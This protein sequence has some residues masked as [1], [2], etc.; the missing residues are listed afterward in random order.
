MN[1][2]VV[3]VTG[4][5]GGVGR[6]AAREFAR[7]GDSVALLARGEAGLDGARLDVEAMGVRALPVSVDVADADAVEAAADRVEK[8]LGPVDVWVNNAMTTVFSPVSDIEPE[9]Y[10]RATEVTYLGGVWGTMAALRRMRPRGRGKIVNVGSALAYRSIPLQ[11]AY[12]GAKFALRGFTDSVRCEL[13]HE[14]SGVGITMVHL[15]GLD[16]PQFSWCRAKL[17]KTPQPVPP[18]YEPEVA[19]RAIEWASRNDRREV[20]VGLPVYKTI[21]GNKVAPGFLDRYLADHAW[22][23]QFTDEPLG[24]ER[25]GNL[26]EPVDDERDHGAHGSFAD[27]SRTWSPVL[28]GSLHPGWLAFGAV[29]LGI[30]TAWLLGRRD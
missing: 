2:R 24:G 6:A 8:E 1:G 10:R 17:P 15:P 13:I 26:F 21:L 19:A 4:A 23:G 7:A 14:S 5:S 28:E 9:E 25:D 11:S 29:A 18:I 20:W 12:C 30:A 16:T 3:V 27:R 22:E